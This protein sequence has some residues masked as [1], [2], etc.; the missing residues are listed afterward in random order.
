LTAGL[1]AVY[2]GLA[3]IGF[4]DWRRSMVSGSLA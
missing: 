2:V 1:Y 3:V 4:R